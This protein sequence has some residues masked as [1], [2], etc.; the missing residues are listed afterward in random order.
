MYFLALFFS[1]YTVS[2]Y[3]FLNQCIK[4]FFCS[5]AAPTM[6]VKHSPNNNF[7]YKHLQTLT[8][9]G[10]AF[11]YDMFLSFGIGF[12]GS[13]LIMSCVFLIVFSCLELHI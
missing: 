8:Y 7:I 1:L 10:F 12:G 13:F 5:P 9:Q 4:W 2:L 6:S 11:F 3:S